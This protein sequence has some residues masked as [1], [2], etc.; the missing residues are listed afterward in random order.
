MSTSPVLGLIASRIGYE[1]RRIFEAAQARGLTVD[2]LDPRKRFFDRRTRAPADVYLNREIASDRALFAARSLEAAGLL[3]VNSANAHQTASDKWLTQLMLESEGVP[4]PETVAVTS[5]EMFAALAERLPPPW[6]LKHRRGSWG[7]NILRVG[8]VDVAEAT[9]SLMSQIPS[10]GTDIVLVQEFVPSDADLR[11]IVVDGR[12]VGAI[13]RRGEGWRHNVA[14]G[15]S[16]VRHE[17][18]QDVV[19]I[20]TRVAD[21]LGLDVCGVDLLRREDSTHVVLEANAR[22]EFKGFERAHGSVVAEHLIDL[23]LRRTAKRC[24]A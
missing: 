12:V 13:E 21:L 18:G 7:R 5:H 17:A 20:S 6:V 15:S 11:V 23:C 1:E 10:S 16:T 14:L 2:H 19:D 4:M 22:V 3:V 8:S 24:A 9:Y